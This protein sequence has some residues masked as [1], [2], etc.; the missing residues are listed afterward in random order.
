MPMPMKYTNASS[1]FDRFL[2]DVQ[3]SCMLQKTHQA[4]QTLRAVLLV[5]ARTSAFETHSLRSSDFFL[6]TTAVFQPP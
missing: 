1:D 3:D 5:F 6:E 2:A 4:Y